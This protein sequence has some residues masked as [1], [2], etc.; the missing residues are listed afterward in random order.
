MSAI[1]QLDLCNLEGNL[2]LNGLHTLFV[3]NIEGI[4]D[5][6]DRTI[7]LLNSAPTPVLDTPATSMAYAPAVVANWSGTAPTSVANA[8]DRIA[9]ALG[10]IA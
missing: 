10:P 4:P 6:R 2:T 7:T 1:C 8:L 5:L 9:A 3:A